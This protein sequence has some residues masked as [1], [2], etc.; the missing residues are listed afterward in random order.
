MAAWRC[1]GQ[2]AEGFEE[3]NARLKKLLTESMMDVSTLRGMLEKTS[4]AQLKEVIHP[5]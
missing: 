1:R 3:E 4:D 5:H 2:T